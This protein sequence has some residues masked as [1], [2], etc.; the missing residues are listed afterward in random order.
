MF[1]VV[2]GRLRIYVNKFVLFRVLVGFIVNLVLGNRKLY[3]RVGRI[4]NRR[5]YFKKRKE[6]RVILE[7]FFEVC[8]Y[9]RFMVFL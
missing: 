8:K 4:R 7:L 9:F 3:F 2:S 6:I 5:F 1:F